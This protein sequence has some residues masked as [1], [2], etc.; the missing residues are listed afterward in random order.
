[1]RYL[2]L[3][4]ALASLAFAQDPVAVADNPDPTPDALPVE[5][6][7][8]IQVPTFTEATGVTAREIPSIRGRLTRRILEAKSDMSRKEWYWRL[9]IWRAVYMVPVVPYSDLPMY[10]R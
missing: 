5:D 4:P 9:Q 2:I 10:R 3:L 8:D 1:M 7:R 6:L